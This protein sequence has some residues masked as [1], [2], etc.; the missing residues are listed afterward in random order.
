MNRNNIAIRTENLTKNYGDVVAAKDV[1]VEVLHGE[2][3]GLLGP[4]GAGKTTLIE[5]LIGALSPTSGTAKVLGK[6]II[7]ESLEVRKLIGYLPEGGSFYHEMSAFRYLCYMAE[8]GGLDKDKAV[9]KA[10]DLLEKMGLAE[11]RDSKIATY[12]SGMKQRLAIAQAFIT[13]PKIVFLDEPTS[14]LD[15]LVREE[16]LAMID[17][18]VQT[19]KTIVLASHILPETK[20]IC[21][22]IAIMDQGTVKTEARLADIDGSLE[23]FYKKTIGGEDTQ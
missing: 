19:D 18:Y 12:S 6:D 2:V 4:N 9:T 21:D 23:V 13:D 10:Q 8:L 3:Y 22:S 14:D 5:M 20:Q 17:E 15:P 1:N 7:T 11:R 16:I